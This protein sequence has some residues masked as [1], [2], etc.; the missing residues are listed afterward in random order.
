MTMKTGIG[1][2]LP[3]LIGLAALLLPL[4][5]QA[6]RRSPLADAPA[7]RKRLELRE[8][9]LELG[10]GLGS[11]LN[12]DFYHTVLANVKLGFHFTDWLSISGFAGFA[13]ANISTGFQSRV[14]ETLNMNRD[15][16][17]IAREPTSA[18]ATASMQKISSMLGLQLE[19]TP[20]TGKYSL[21][22]KL[23][24][25]YD[26]YAFLG[27]GF[28][29]VA[30]TTPGLTL[31]ACDGAMNARACD[32]SGLKPGGNVGVGMHT[33]FNQWLGLNVEVRDI[34]ARLNPSGRDVNGDGQA[35]AND[36]TWTSTFSVLANLVVYLPA[37][38]DI[39][40]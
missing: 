40:Q 22:G 35:D 7:I 9:R 29:N 37:T 8:T 4:A 31:P 1:N 20:F 34:I 33:Y 32:V 16:A 27:P 15:P 13:A 12:Q 18:E 19:F 36:L 5:A 11:T 17:T 28:I 2:R 38:A 24:A 39:S 14:T 10:A 3:L 30:P 26:F 6:Q 21:F 23:F 25:H